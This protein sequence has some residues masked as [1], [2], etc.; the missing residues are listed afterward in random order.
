M[1]DED[2][3]ELWEFEDLGEMAEG[4]AG[5][6]AFVI[7]SALDARGQAVVALPVSDTVMPVLEQLAKAQIK[8]KHVVIIPTDDR[9]V[10]VDD[11]RSHV[12][13]LAQMFMTRGARVFPMATENKDYHLAGSAANSRLHDLHW[14]LDLVWL[15]Q[16]KDGGAAGLRPGPDLGDALYGAKD[17]RACGV[18]IDGEDDPVVTITGAAIY[19]AKTVM[20]SVNGQKEAARLQSAIAA[21]GKGD[22]V[23]GKIFAA[24]NVPVDIYVAP[25]A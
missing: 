6:I 8:W 22:D 7:E 19:A 18:K 23:I 4:L 14:P 12:R 13:K 16:S 17:I 9:L 1:I 10:A 21:R 25:G 24:L 2:E 11:P 15:S 3:I 5:D 20:I